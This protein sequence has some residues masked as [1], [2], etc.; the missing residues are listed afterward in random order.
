MY[1]NDQRKKERKTRDYVYDQLEYISQSLGRG[2]AHVQPLRV[3]TEARVSLGRK[4]ELTCSPA[5][6]MNE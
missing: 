2:P 6:Y 1:T 4:Q 3:W 5:I